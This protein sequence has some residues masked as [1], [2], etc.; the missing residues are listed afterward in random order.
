M[1]MQGS[2][3]HH[4]RSGFVGVAS[5]AALLALTACGSATPDEVATSKA[6]LS[7]VA[8][9]LLGLPRGGSGGTRYSWPAGNKIIY[10]LQI[11]SGAYVDQLAVHYYDPSNWDNSYTYPDRTGLVGPY[12]GSGG[13]VQ[14]YIT[15]PNGYAAFGITGKYGKYVDALGL[16]CAD[17]LSPRYDNSFVQGEYGGTGG[18]F[19]DDWCP[20]GQLLTGINM[21]AGTY[22]DQVQ[23]LC[24]PAHTCDDP[25]DPACCD[26]NIENCPPQ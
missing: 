19:F 24:S 6:R 13:V 26:P 14:P 11:H 16:R 10:Q 3:E 12:G 9:H 22:V 20:D 5:I 18:G 1:V 2:F 15:C 8:P 23:G 7:E 17:E 25:S 21:R 4:E